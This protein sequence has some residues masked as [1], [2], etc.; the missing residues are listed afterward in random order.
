MRQRG[1]A[2][3]TATLKQQQQQRLALWVR[4]NTDCNTARGTVHQRK[5]SCRGPDLLSDAAT[6]TCTSPLQ[7]DS[8]NGLPPRP[9]PNTGRAAHPNDNLTALQ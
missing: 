9:P 5:R 3:H 2:G 4:S 1:R 8:T 7:H 6:T